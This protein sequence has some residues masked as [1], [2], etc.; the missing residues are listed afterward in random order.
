MILKECLAYTRQILAD[1]NIDD[2]PLEG[3]LLLRQALKLNRVQLYQSFG[4]EL[5]QR[6]QEALQLLVGRRLKGEPSAYITGHCE[7]YGL[8]FYVNKSVLIPRP[9]TEHLVEKLINLA[10][11]HK[12]P[13][14]TDTGTGCGTIAISLALNLPHA[15]IYATDISSPALDIARLNCCK[16][17]VADRIHLLA[18]NMLAPL[19]EQVD[20]IAANLPYVRQSEIESGGFEPILALNGGTDGMEKITRLCH[21]AA[22]KLRPGGCLLL[23][24]GQGQREVI[25]TLLRSLF[26]TSGIEVT[27][28]LSG[29]DRV[30]TMALPP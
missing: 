18:G 25:T 11:N 1:K 19:P 2:A 17:R 20:F 13:L 6:Q 3:E 21:Q 24:I 23:E 5:N 15:R 10:Q 8:D 27:P 9:E 12:S 30:V 7:F 16:H 14:I 26:P 4:Q 22:S 28:D 29:I